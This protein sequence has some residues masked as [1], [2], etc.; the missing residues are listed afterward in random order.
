MLGG[1]GEKKRNKTHMSELVSESEPH[2][3]PQKCKPPLCIKRVSPNP[4]LCSAAF[5]GPEGLTVSCDTPL[6]LPR[7]STGSNALSL[8]PSVPAAWP[9]PGLLLARISCE[10]LATKSAGG[11]YW[12]LGHTSLALTVPVYYLGILRE[13]V[14]GT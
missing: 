9:S 10:S 14:P 4:P 12:S 3:S 5:R 8:V 7:S 13:R 11:F 6:R 1:M 2:K